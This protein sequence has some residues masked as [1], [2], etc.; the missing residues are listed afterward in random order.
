MCATR[1]AGVENRR[2]VCSLPVTLWL[3]FRFAAL[4]FLPA[5]PAD[6]PSLHQIALAEA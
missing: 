5:R 1:A 4:G 6:E 3:G 2:S